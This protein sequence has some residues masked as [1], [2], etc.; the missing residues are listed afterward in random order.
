MTLSPA[1][2]DFIIREIG[3]VVCL[4]RGIEGKVECAKHHLLTTGHH[5]NGKRRGEQAT[6]GLCDY[7]HQGAHVVGTATARRL[8]AERGPSYQD[9]P[10]EFRALYPDSLLLAEQ[11]RLIAKHLE[12]FVA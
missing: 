9:N 3:C 2:R 5:G 11:N 1:R 8:Y 10:K 6:V 4:L 12:R 7:H